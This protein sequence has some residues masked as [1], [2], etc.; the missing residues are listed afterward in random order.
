MEVSWT[1]V[2]GVAT[3]TAVITNLSAPSTCPGVDERTWSSCNFM[4]EQPEKAL[5]HGV[6]G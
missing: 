2:T 4:G 1:V 5:A 3:L 6:H